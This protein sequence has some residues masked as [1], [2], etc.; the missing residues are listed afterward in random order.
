MTAS[1]GPCQPWDAIWPCTVST[2]SPEVTGYAVEAATEVVWALSGRRFGTCEVSLRPCRRSALSDLFLWDF[3]RF[4]SWANTYSSPLL[5]GYGRFGLWLDIE[6]GCG[7]ICGCGRLS[8]IE[9]PA[10]VN[11]VTSV[12]VD[13]T[14]LDPTAYRM[15]DNR[16]LVRIDGQH[17]PR[18]NDLA[19]GDDQPGTWSVTAQY[20]E[21]VPMLGRMAVGEMACQFVRAL[22]GKDCSLPPGVTQLARQGV[23]IQLPQPSELF[24]D[25]K[26]GLYTVDAFIASAN[27]HNLVRRSRV[28][29]VDRRPPRRTDT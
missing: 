13:G 26:T 12:L 14:P 4:S 20:G 21:D 1:F 6:C 25:G 17:W 15:D 11:T 19:K 18:Y 8:Q 9:L 16:Y 22:E 23:T 2:A 5:Y 3:S 10:P 24:K 28:Y 27:P 7:G 29:S